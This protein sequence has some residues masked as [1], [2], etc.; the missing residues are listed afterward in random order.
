KFSLTQSVPE[1][2]NRKR[3][4]FNDAFDHK[5]DL[6]LLKGVRTLIEDLYAHNF[7]LIL[8]S[9]AANVTINRVFRRFGLSPYFSAIVSGED[10]PK[11]KPDPA[12]FNYAASL[13]IAS[14]EQCIVIEDSTNG[15]LAAKGAGIYCIGYN[16]EHSKRQD[17]SRAD[18]VI[19]HFS[20]L[21]S[22]VIGAIGG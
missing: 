15:V 21:N 2:V 4:I 9:S 10:F 13:S 19:N 12:I 18:Q 22:S 6:D 11:S 17:L 3:E 14:K 1:L 20:E 8:A 7:Q 16:S 5:E